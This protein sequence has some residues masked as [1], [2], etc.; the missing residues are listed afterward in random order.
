MPEFLNKTTYN[1]ETILQQ[2][3][4][5]E[6]LYIVTRDRYFRYTL[7]CDGKKVGTKDSPL[8]FSQLD[9]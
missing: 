4:V 9:E 3:I 7:W 6:K 1:G 5:K 8:E 2:Q